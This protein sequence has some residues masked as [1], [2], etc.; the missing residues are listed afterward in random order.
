MRAAD[1][2]DSA[3]RLNL[4]A[5]IYELSA[6]MSHMWATSEQG[7]LK[8]ATHL[9]QLFLPFVP[10]SVSNPLVH[11][12]NYAAQLIFC[13]SGSLIRPYNR[14]FKSE[15]GKCKNSGTVID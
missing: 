8:N 1:R 2:T 15:K 5:A 4:P 6:T 3:E 12:V 14:S 11:S 13:F 10:Y 7:S 9:F